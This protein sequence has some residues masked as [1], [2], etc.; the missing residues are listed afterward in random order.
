MVETS[1]QN[2]IREQFMLW[3][4]AKSNTFTPYNRSYYPIIKQFL[5]LLEQHA[6]LQGH[7]HL[8]KQ[9]KLIEEKIVGHL[10]ELNSVHRVFDYVIHL[11]RTLTTAHIAHIVHSTGLHNLEGD[12]VEFIL[13]CHVQVY[14][15]N[16]H[17]TW[18]YLAALNSEEKL[19]L[20]PK[21][22]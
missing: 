16:V 11:P 7:K 20:S 18:L 22:R 5:S 3:R 10:E 17:S 2:Y 4:R 12:H 14:S 6:C 8:H 19:A 9:Q 1:I 13:A 15:A 21:N